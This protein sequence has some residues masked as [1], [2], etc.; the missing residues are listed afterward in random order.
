MPNTIETLSNEELRNV[1]CRIHNCLPTTSH[2]VTFGKTHKSRRDARELNKVRI[3][4][5]E[6]LSSGDE[7]DIE[8]LI[9]VV[10]DYHRQL[11]IIQRWV[12]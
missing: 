9:V 11:H 6:V 3:D 1:G 8:M 2:S 10:L 12:S 7:R 5:R 4:V